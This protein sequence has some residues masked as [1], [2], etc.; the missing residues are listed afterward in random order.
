MMIDHSDNVIDLN[1]TAPG[2][3]YD[4]PRDVVADNTLSIGEK[5]PSSHPG[6]RILL[7]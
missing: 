5:R 4:H 3:V 7:R 1:A 6:R 2:S